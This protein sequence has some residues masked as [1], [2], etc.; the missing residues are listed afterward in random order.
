MNKLN[1]PF[2]GNLDTSKLDKVDV[3]W[4]RDFSLADTS[5]EVCLWAGPGEPLDARMLDALAALLADLPALDARARRF[6]V[7]D[8]AQDKSFIEFYVEDPDDML[9]VIEAL[10]P[11]GDADAVDVGAFV[12]AMTLMNIGLWPVPVTG[13]VVMDYM[14]DPENSDQILAVKLDENGALVSIDWES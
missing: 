1:H 10:A 7:E 3:I 13:P 2:F 14:I 11:D 4:S 8:M 6:L 5:F 9:P 12:K